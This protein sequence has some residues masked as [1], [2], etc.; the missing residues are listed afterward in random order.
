MPIS[1]KNFVGAAALG[2]SAASLSKVTPALAQ[3][4]DERTPLHFHILK[5]H[6]FDHAQ[7]LQTLTLAKPHKQVFQN[8]INLL[9][10]PGVAQLYI[11]MQNSM[12]AHEFSMG[13]GRGS[14]ATLGV[15]MG[16]AVVLALND[17]VWKKYGIGNAFKL[18]STN[19][20]YKATSNLKLTGSPDDPSS[21][22]Q[23]WS[24]QAVMARGGKFMVCHN[25]MTAVA[26]MTAQKAG[27]T[28]QAV[29]ADFEK[30]VLPGFQ[31]VPAGVAAVQLA[32]QHGYTLFAV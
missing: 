31:V 7:M 18:A 19:M 20:Y 17:A 23:D 12:N 9:L 14:L 30:G 16:P 26:A 2:L 29:L 32:Q 15:L 5:Q 21:V 8:S 1:R 28:P 10:V 25:A 24:A 27:S 22:Y 3:D 4:S 13:F 6:E 11:H